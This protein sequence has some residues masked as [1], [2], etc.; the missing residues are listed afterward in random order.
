M[1]LKSAQCEKYY[2]GYKVLR[3]WEKKSSPWTQTSSS[4]SL[5]FP[6]SIFAPTTKAI[7]N[8]KK[9][10]PDLCPA[11]NRAEKNFK[12]LFSP[13]KIKEY[14][15]EIHLVFSTP[16]RRNFPVKSS[17]TCQDFNLFFKCSFLSQTVSGFSLKRAESYCNIKKK[18]GLCLAHSG[19]R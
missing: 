8:N 17:T 4:F 19:W 6:H 3:V 7:K 13:A 15:A 12:L 11:E 9:I 2:I 5:Q 16:V 1:H 10:S 14:S 18:N